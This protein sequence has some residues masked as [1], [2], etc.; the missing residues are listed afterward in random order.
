[1]KY[2]SMFTRCTDEFKDQCLAQTRSNSMTLGVILLLSVLS[3]TQAHTAPVDQYTQFTTGL[4]CGPDVTGQLTLDVDV[5]GTFGTSAPVD[6]GAARSGG[7]AVI[8]E[9][10]GTSIL[11]CSHLS[12]TSMQWRPKR[13]N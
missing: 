1:M 13:S 11:R 2:P 10:T 4:D 8:P 12:T 7:T 3:Y 6:D 5:F 9:P